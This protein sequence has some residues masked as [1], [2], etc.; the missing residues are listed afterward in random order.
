MRSADS[1]TAVYRDGTMASPSPHSTR[2]G[3]SERLD[4]VPRAWWKVIDS[5]IERRYK[6]TSAL[7]VQV[8]KDLTPS[9]LHLLERKTSEAFDSNAQ[10]RPKTG[11]GRLNGPQPKRALLLRR[12]AAIV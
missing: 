3:A 9:F 2:F 10:T 7:A 4:E 8:L 11:A 5:Y 6:F 12:L 1:G